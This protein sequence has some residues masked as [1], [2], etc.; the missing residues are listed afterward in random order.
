MPHT[1]NFPCIFVLSKEREYPPEV[2]HLEILMRIDIESFRDL[3]RSKART[4]DAKKETEGDSISLH[5][6]IV[7]GDQSLH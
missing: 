1:L 6:Q 4:K 2:L 3:L 7:H 5:S